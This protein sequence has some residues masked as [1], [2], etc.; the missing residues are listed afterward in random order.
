[1][2]FYQSLI[3]CYKWKHIW[4]AELQFLL[5]NKK[6]F[7]FKENEETN[8]KELYLKAFKIIKFINNNISL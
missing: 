1:M 8:F 5:E 4:L 2:I 3:A 6:L 7:N